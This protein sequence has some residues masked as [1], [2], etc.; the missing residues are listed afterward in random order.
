MTSKLSKNED[1][2]T[3]F[4]FKQ[5]VDMA[6]AFLP[7]LPELRKYCTFSTAL[8]QS[9]V[10]V[11][12]KRP[13]ESATGSGLL[14]P[15]DH[16][17]WLLVLTAVLFVGPIIYVFATLRFVE[18]CAESASKKRILKQLFLIYYQC[19]LG[20]SCGNNPTLR[21]LV[22]SLA[23]GLCTVPCWNKDRLYSRPQVCDYHALLNEKIL[24]IMSFI[25]VW[26]LYSL[27]THLRERQF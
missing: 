2:I 26:R 6:V 19:L 24:I 14:A 22:C 15:F 10:T 3:R 1:I 25:Y 18:S 16:T 23:Y 8:D 12:M 27:R 17:V 7:L 21:I 13:Q 5:K 9:E 11:L 4:A 20:R